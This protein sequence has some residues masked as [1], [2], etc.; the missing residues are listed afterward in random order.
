MMAPSVRLLRLMP[1][2]DQLVPVTVAVTGGL[3]CALPASLATIVTVAPASTVPVAVAL[4]ALVELTGLVAV[5]IV[6]VGATVSLIE[7]EVTDAVSCDAS[8]A[9][10]V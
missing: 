2:A 5:V 6:T 1:V 7:V 3:V 10:A 8:V 9:V 4:E